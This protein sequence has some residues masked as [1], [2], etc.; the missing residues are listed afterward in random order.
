ME[1]WLDRGRGE[2]MRSSKVTNRDR[3]S[4]Q[5]HTKPQIT[6]KGTPE[7]VASHQPTNKA[8]EEEHITL[9]SPVREPEGNL[10]ELQEGGEA[11]NTKFT[12]SIPTKFIP[13]TGQLGTCGDA[14]TVSEPLAQTLPY[15]KV[16]GG[17]SL[18]RV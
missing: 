5:S 9:H 7:A 16:G 11:T 4:K 1:Q 12:I 15:H 14:G 3:K 13:E 8:T 17:R 10:G 18:P 6:S 2:S